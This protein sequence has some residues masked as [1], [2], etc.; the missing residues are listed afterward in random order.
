MLIEKQHI[1]TLSIKRS[2]EQQLF[3]IQLPKNAKK[4]TGIHVSIQVINS[5]PNT[6]PIANATVPLFSLEQVLY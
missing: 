4:I 1:H 3:Q 2:G 6:A 5:T